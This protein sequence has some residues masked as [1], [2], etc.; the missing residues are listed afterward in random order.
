MEGV[1]RWFLH[2]GGVSFI[3]QG[4]SSPK[5]SHLVF[6]PV[7][8]YKIS[9]IKI[10]KNEKKCIHPSEKCVRQ[11]DTLYLCQTRDFTILQGNSHYG[12]LKARTSSLSR[13]HIGI[14]K[15]RVHL[16]SGADW[17]EAKGPAWYRGSCGDT[18]MSQETSSSLKLFRNFCVSLRSCRL[19]CTG[20]S[21]LPVL[22]IFTGE[23]AE[24]LRAFL[25]A[26]SWPL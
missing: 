2:D 5:C 6:G 20:P 15:S 19:F 4:Q 18:H 22:F 14:K 26:T 3:L 23:A 9:F 7:K 24:G 12:H 10:F 17:G 8:S 25:L 11:L 21:F 13:Y 16:N 1:T